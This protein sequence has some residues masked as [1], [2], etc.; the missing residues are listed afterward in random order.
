MLNRLS[1][2]TLDSKTPY[3]VWFG[4]KP[5]VEHLR[6]FGSICYMHIPEIKRD[7]LDK[8]AEIGILVGYSNT[9]KGFR[10]YGL[11]SNKLVICR[12]V[13]VDEHVV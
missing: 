7:K 9:T 10:V 6:I 11:K 5:T 2:K 3:E 4:M 13:I 12:N 8:K 1:T